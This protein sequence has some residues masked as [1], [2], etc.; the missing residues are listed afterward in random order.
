ML[1]T[2]ESPSKFGT[3][4]GNGLWIHDSE[5][6]YVSRRM[7]DVVDHGDGRK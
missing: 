7:Q 3:M 1:L 4:F 6:G 2:N 5:L